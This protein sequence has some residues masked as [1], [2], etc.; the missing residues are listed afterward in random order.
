MCFMSYSSFRGSE[1]ITEMKELDLKELPA[2]TLLS[3]FQFPL[4]LQECLS[5]G[6]IHVY[7]QMSLLKLAALLYPD[8]LV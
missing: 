4:H 1:R 8:S 3:F 7:I 2:C 6:G 5:D